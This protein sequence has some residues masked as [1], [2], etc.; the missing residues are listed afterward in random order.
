MPYNG[1]KSDMNVFSQ[2]V[3]IYETKIKFQWKYND[4]FKI[5]EQ[6]SYIFKHKVQPKVKYATKEEIALQTDF[7]KQTLFFTKNKVQIIDFCRHFRNSFVHALMEKQGKSLAITDI[8]RNNETC[9]G[10]LDYAIVKEF[11]VQI[12]N[13]YEE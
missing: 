12:I 8:Y 3:F 1:L 5:S 6:A 13:D 9:K 7:L 4:F 11:I 2:F 10:T